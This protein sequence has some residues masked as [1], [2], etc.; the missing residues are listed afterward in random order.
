MLEGLGR[1][2]I[3]ILILFSGIR[4]GDLLLRGRGALLFTPGRYACEYV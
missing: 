1:T 2:M 4:I 3:P